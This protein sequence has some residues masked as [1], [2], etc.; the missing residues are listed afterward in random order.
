MQRILARC[1]PW[2]R[3]LS[4]SKPCDTESGQILVDPTSGLRVHF[5]PKKSVNI[6]CWGLRDRCATHLLVCVFLRGDRRRPTSNLI[7]C[8][9][10]WGRC[11]RSIVGL[12]F[13][14]VSA[15]IAGDLMFRL[16][17]A[18]HHT[19]GNLSAICSLLFILRR[20]GVL[21]WAATSHVSNRGGSRC[22][23][24]RAVRTGL[25][26]TGSGP[27]QWD[28]CPLDPSSARPSP[29]GRH[30]GLRPHVCRIP[31]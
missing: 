16:V 24:S 19:A 1:C 21:A 7:L 25:G 28:R 17:L 12:R 22:L 4:K 3:H 30:P 26:R 29:G 9:S 10:L 23:R 8:M 14:C 15:R 5:R 6:C 20:F 31:S 18:Q 11:R 27:C 2:H 13:A